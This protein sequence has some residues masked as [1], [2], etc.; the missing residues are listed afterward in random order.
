M[1]VRVH[2]IEDDVLFDCDL[3]DQRITI[4]VAR[5]PDEEL[6]VGTQQTVATL[7]GRVVALAFFATDVFP[8]A[9]RNAITP[10]MIAPVPTARCS[11]KRSF[12]RKT[13]IS[14]A[15]S[16]EVSRNAATAAT[17]ARVIAQSAMP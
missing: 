16:T 10:A 3:S 12:S 4:G 14:A 6:A 5:A 13:P 7:I 17:G 11:R 8:Q 1:P 15:N 2:K 9:R